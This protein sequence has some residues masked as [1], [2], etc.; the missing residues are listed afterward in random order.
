MR[1]LVVV[2]VGMIGGCSAS[3][4][5]GFGLV[6][7]HDAV[8]DDGVV[9][10]VHGAE[11]ELV[12]EGKVVERAPRAVGSTF[13]LPFEGRTC[14]AKVT[15]IGTETSTTTVGKQRPTLRSRELP[16]TDLRASCTDG[17]PL[18]GSDAALR[19]A[20]SLVGLAWLLPVLLCAWLA[21]C[22]IRPLDAQQRPTGGAIG[23]A[24]LGILLGLASIVVPAIVAFDDLY[25]VSYPLLATGMAFVVFV[26]FGPGRKRVS[27]LVLLSLLAIPIFALIFPHWSPGGP[28][29]ALGCAFPI[30]VTLVA[31]L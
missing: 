16:T 30:W 14:V 13:A 5:L 28:V 25:R 6:G 2:L 31:V 21:A 8:I 10:R 1:I 3:D 22:A 4:E 23:L 20:R 15:A 27:N 7:D 9:V 12:Y 19:G 11:V 24:I 18:P 29:A 17:R 26:Q